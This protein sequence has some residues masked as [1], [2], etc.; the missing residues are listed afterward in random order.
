MKRKNAERQRTEKKT[1]EDR[2]KNLMRVEEKRE[3]KEIPTII[4]NWTGK[5]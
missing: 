3:K 5:K 4:L 2:R 1:K